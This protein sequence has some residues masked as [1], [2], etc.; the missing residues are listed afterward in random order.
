MDY[1]KAKRSL[2]DAD[3][4]MKRNGYSAFMKCHVAWSRGQTE[5][6]PVILLDIHFKNVPEL[7]YIKE[8]ERNTSKETCTLSV[9]GARLNGLAK[10]K[11][12]N[13]QK[14]TFQFES[15]ILAQDERWRRA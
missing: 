1:Q 5:L 7:F 14:Q 11:S 3:K 2:Q 10:Q 12:W 13:N 8:E 9:Q 15:L 6:V 4:R